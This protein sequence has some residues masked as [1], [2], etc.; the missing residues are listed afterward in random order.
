[1]NAVEDSE[2]LEQELRSRVPAAAATTVSREPI[3]YDHPLFYVVFGLLTGLAFTLAVRAMSTLNERGVKWTTLGIACYSLALGA[4][5]LLARP[6]AQRY[7]PK[8]RLGDILLGS[9][10]LLSGVVLAIHSLLGSGT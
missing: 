2:R 1:M 7:G 10:G 3:D 6:I 9:L 4:Y 5:V 8:S